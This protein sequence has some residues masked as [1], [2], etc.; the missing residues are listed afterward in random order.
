M[1]LR[2][3]SAGRRGDASK[4]RCSR[5]EPLGTACQ[6]APASG[7]GRDTWAFCGEQC[8][9]CSARGADSFVHRQRGRVVVGV[10]GFGRG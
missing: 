10:G 1:S 9:L 3:D 6:Q 2:G 8:D 7:D 5:S 4:S